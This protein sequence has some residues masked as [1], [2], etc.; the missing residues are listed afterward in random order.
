MT[1]AL[2]AADTSVDSVSFGKPLDG[3]ATSVATKAAV[4]TD[5]ISGFQSCYPQQEKVY[6]IFPTSHLP[7]SNWRPALYEGANDPFSLGGG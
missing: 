6:L 1:G 3:T 4:T 2:L 7:E 5:L